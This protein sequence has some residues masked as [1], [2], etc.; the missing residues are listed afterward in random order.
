MPP[1]FPP[2]EPVTLR[3]ATVSQGTH[4][5][6]SHS[7]QGRPSS[8]QGWHHSATL[9]QASLWT[10]LSCKMRG[11]VETRV[12]EYRAWRVG[13]GSYYCE[14]SKAG[15]N[16]SWEVRVPGVGKVSEGQ[17]LGQTSLFW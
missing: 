2:R 5:P 15:I 13:R 17:N 10:H 14:E 6:A 1:T 7:L 8:L 16:M 12:L 4:P 3:W 11:Q 9:P